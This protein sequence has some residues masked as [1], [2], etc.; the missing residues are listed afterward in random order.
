MKTFLK[1]TGEFLKVY[2]QIRLSRNE[3]ILIRNEVI[4]HLGLNNINEMRDRFEG[5]AFFDK[6]IMN[7]GGLMAIQKHLDLPIVNIS[8]INLDGYSPYL[9]INNEVI[10]V[11][12]FEFGKIPLFDDTKLKNKVFFVIQKDKTTFNL[13][14]FLDI[15][16]I[17]ENVIDVNT[18]T[19][20]Q[21]G[22]KGFIGFDKLNKAEDLI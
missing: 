21:A 14:G 15:K 10:N 2:P 16:T 12:V 6:T 17:K 11:M 5:Q 13:C 19:H 7:V 20:S 9:E 8:Q 1:Y 18:K 22:F 4:N 3:E